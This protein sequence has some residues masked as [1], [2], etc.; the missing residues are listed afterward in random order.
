M[1]RETQK[2]IQGVQGALGDAINFRLWN[3]LLLGKNGMPT[4]AVHVVK[5]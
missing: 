1:Q 5:E 2:G 3:P 4:F